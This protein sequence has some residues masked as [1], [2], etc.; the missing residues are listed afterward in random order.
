MRRRVATAG[1]VAI[2]PL[3]VI[4]A[5]AKKP[6]V[7]CPGGRFLVQG[8]QLVAGT[9]TGPDDVMIDRASRVVSIDTNITSC[10]SI[11]TKA[12]GVACGSNTETCGG[13]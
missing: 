13:P 10:G 8:R 3:L 7:D 4:A 11:C 12:V 6:T 9:G 1:G 2:L 5:H